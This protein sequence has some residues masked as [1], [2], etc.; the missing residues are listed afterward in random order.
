MTVGQ[1]S[2]ISR[3]RVHGGLSLRR[4]G[5]IRRDSL[6]ILATDSSLP[7]KRTRRR[8]LADELTCETLTTIWLSAALALLPEEQRT[9]LELCDEV[10]PNLPRFPAASIRREAIAEA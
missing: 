4:Q 10:E 6:A 3:V 7:L 2:V 9:A 8:D 1:E 5:C